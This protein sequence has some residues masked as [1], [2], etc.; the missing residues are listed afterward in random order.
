MTGWRLEAGGWRQGA[1]AAVLLLAA[2][3]VGCSDV[4]QLA[5]TLSTIGRE[6]AAIE[7]EC[8]QAA[9]AVEAGEDPRPFVD[10]A[11]ERAGTIRSAAETGQKAL[12]GVQDRTPW[13]ATTATWIAAAAALLAVAW[14]AGGAVRNVLA[15]LIP[16]PAV[17]A[18]AAL[19]AKVLHG[20]S[21][22]Q[23]AVAARR[24]SDP[25]YDKAFQKAN[26]ALEGATP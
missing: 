15:R 12:A 14:M 16:P 22:P 20:R 3:L 10:R 17:R 23:E 24:A 6:A 7:D 9:E 5:G 21:T 8:R 2:T 25:A 19:D 4:R 13:W 11:A 1:A 26:E 18:S